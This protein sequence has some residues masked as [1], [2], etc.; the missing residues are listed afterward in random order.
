MAELASQSFEVG[1][2][3]MKLPDL[4]ACP[5]AADEG[6]NKTRAAPGEVPFEMISDRGS[7]PLASTII[8]VERSRLQT[9]LT[10]FRL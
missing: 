9:L 3:I 8:F 2:T 7:I 5:W 4:A 6:K 1:R 10:S